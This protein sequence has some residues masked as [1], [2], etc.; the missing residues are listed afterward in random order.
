MGRISIVSIAVAAFL[1]LHQQAVVGHRQAATANQEAQPTFKAESNLVVLHVSVRDR[2][3]RYITGLERDAFTVIDDG[4]P[5]TLEMFSG[6]DVP[7]SVGF[8]IDNSNSM[9]ANRERV[10]A[11]ALEFAKHSHPK[12]QIFVL[13][14]NEQVR[15]AFGPTLISELNLGVFG[16]VMSKAISARGMTAIYDGI[17]E[18]LK[19]VSAGMH[20]RQVLVV[21]SD[22]DDNASTAT[23]DEVIKQVQESDAVIYTI[24]L[25]DPLTREGN[26]GL[27]RRLARS[28]GGESFQPRRA[29]E[30][31]EAFDR[32]ATD[33]RSG[34]TLAYAPTSAASAGDDDRDRRRRTVRVYVRSKDGKALR[35]RT[36]DGYFE[37]AGG[38]TP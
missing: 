25:I 18:G 36:R 33:I 27:M 16:S 11:A 20:T 10:I 13:T 21:V 4:K 24:A 8:L 2:G 26:P 15:H 28:T 31:S 17:L 1:I 14:F 5:Q 30:V 9:R 29:D 22:G 23:L 12:D 35:V 38:G 6:D 37:R 34:Y 7:A 3:G 19:R 32:I